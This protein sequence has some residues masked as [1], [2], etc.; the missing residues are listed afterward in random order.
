MPMTDTDRVVVVVS[1]HLSDAGR[2]RKNPAAREKSSEATQS[3]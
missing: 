1:I 3:T 2:D